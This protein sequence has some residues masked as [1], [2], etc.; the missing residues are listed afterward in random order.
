VTPVTPNY[1]LDAEFNWVPKSF[2]KPTARPD[3]AQLFSDVK[4]AFKAT[5]IFFFYPCHLKSFL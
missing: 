5:F 4:R 1:E 3:P 2:L